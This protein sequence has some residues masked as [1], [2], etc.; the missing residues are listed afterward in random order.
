M[1][2]FYAIVAALLMAGMLLTAEDLAENTE[3]EAA[4]NRQ[5][6][7]P[8]SF[9]Y[10]TGDQ[11]YSLSAGPLFN[12]FFWTPADPQPVVNGKMKVGGYI[13]IGWDAYFNHRASLGAELGYGFARAID[14]RLYNAVPFLGKISYLLIDGSFSLPISFSA[15]LVYSSYDSQHY[16]GSMVKPEIAAVISLNDEWALGLKT[17]Y[18][19]IPELYF[20][21]NSDQTSFGNFLTV[22]AA[23]TYSQQ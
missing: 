8:A 5:T 22:K 9:R 2:K 4:G 12:L 15:G 10:D 19:F 11:V 3:A 13:S 18:W 20:G 7:A 14:D 17:S 23:V 21:D 1:K 16:L 6:A